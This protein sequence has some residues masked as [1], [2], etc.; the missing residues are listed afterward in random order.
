MIPDVIWAKPDTVIATDACLGGGGGV[1][2]MLKEYF[3]FEFPLY[4]LEETHNINRLQLVFLVVAVKLWGHCLEG[5]C[6]LLY[7]DNEATVAVVNSG[8]CRD[9]VMLS[10]IKELAYETAC[11]DY[12]LKG[13]HISGQDNRLPDL[14]SRW[15]ISPEYELQFRQLVSQEWKEV[16]VPSSYLQLRDVW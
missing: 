6:I 9:S 5:K 16:R 4:L 2:C 14:L 8:R 12:M 7:C 1:N 3:H 13:V 15:H 11:N 10:W